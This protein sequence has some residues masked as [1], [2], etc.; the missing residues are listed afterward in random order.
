MMA[1]KAAS[2]RATRRTSDSVGRVARR[3]RQ[4][5][6]TIVGLALLAA[7]A[8]ASVAL[9]R[10]T[11]ILTPILSGS[12]RPGLPVGGLAISE[13]VPVDHLAVR[14]VIVFREPINP[15]NQIVHRIVHLRTSKSGQILINTQ[16]DANTVRDPWTLTIRGHYAYVVRWTV[17][18]AGYL[19]VAYQNDR[20]FVLFGVGV[21]LVLVAVGIVLSSARS[22]KRGARETRPGA[23]P[24]ISPAFIPGSTVGWAS[25]VSGEDAGARFLSDG[26]GTASR[27][28]QASPANG[29]TQP[30]I[31]NG[32]AGVAAAERKPVDRGRAFEV[33]N[34]NGALH[35]RRHSR[36]RRHLR[37]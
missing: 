26:N 17:P 14:D 35:R 21:A 27:S 36:S 18:L 3:V 1:V 11:W 37:S 5:L 29:P 10:G 24:E 20:G 15:T 12:M 22:R 28:A 9:I 30:P 31:T 34:T 13:R 16:G 23:P 2:H 4:V 25:E 8:I 33:E 7:V 19:A 6:T 32:S